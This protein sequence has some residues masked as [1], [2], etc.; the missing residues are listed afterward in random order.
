MRHDWNSD[1]AS[2]VGSGN[3]TMRQRTPPLRSGA[4]PRLKHTSAG[5]H[6]A[7]LVL[8]S[9]LLLAGLAAAQPW[10]PEEF[11][12]GYWCGPPAKHNTLASW[13]TIKDC[14]FTWAMSGGYDVA[15]NKTMLDVCRQIGLKAMV[16]DGRL[17]WQTSLGDTWEQTL[18][19]VVRDYAGHPAL[20]GY[21]LTDE[22]NYL[23]F[24]GLG[25]LGQGLQRLDPR[26]LPYINLFPTY[27]SQEQLGTPTYAD[28]LE[29]FLTLVKPAV[30]SW[31]HYC[32][33]VG[34]DGPDYFENLGLVRAASLRSGVPA[35]HIIQAMSFHPGMRAPSDAE[36]R[37]QVY[38]SL[39]YGIKGIMYFVYWSYNDK[40]EE[41][42]IVD[43]Q[44][45]PARLYP[46]VRQLNGEMKTLGKLLL[47][48]TSTGVFHT[49]PTT[50]P[51]AARLGTDAPIRLPD[52][53]PLVIGF[54][55]DSRG[56]EY[57]LIAN[58]THKQPADFKAT[59][60]EHIL[61]VT[62]ISARDLG[63][64]PLR[65]EKQGVALHLEP[66]DGKLFRLTSRFRYPATPAPLSRADFQFNEADPE[67][68]GDLNSLSDPMVKNGALTL[69]VTGSDPH[70]CRSW[71]RLSPDQYSRIRVRMKLPACDPVAQFFWTTSEEPAFR[72]DKYLSFPVKPDGQWHDYEIPVGAHPKWKGKA[73]RAIRLDPTTGGAAAGS[74]VEIDWLIGE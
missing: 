22:P 13:Q 25:R 67:G 37:W 64:T 4:A 60:R 18:R 66:G 57:A 53:K 73:V 55:K 38:T 72:D 48:L 26:H 11:P 8:V 30:L 45:R 29:K 71:L 70:L 43:H 6:A 58:A 36:M 63:E 10:Q 9:G 12:I 47:G 39:A 14:N 21:F 40:P 54:F 27:A 42:G 33:Q 46:I 56:V 17:N 62:E 19:E 41:V 50:P 20:Y 59:L 69:T 32:L 31:D 2:S 7:R 34:Q 16:L 1:K 68:W 5:G 51:G 15:G 74:K 65:I 23:N 24:E 52:D 28:H 3:E 49:G 61:G 35:W 44:G